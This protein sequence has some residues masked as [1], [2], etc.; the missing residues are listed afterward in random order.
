MKHNLGIKACVLIVFTLFTVA[1][2]AQTSI[3]NYKYVIVPE[4]FNFSKEDNQYSLNSTVKFL[5][6]QKGF[7][8]FIG[9][10]E[11]PSIV[12]ANRCNALTAEVVQNSG[13]FVTKL[14]LLLKDCQGNIIFKSKEGRSREKEFSSA[15]NQALRDAFSS[16]NDEP[17]KYDS[18]NDSQQ[19]HV[20]MASVNPSTVPTSAAIGEI[21]DTLYAQSTT[22]GYQLIDMTPKKVLV[23]FKTSMQD[24]FIAEAG[25]WHGVVFKKEGEWIFEYYKNDKLVSQKLSIRF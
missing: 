17:Y 18:T 25:A 7:T 22:N 6:D 10:K 15:Y 4:R 1:G 2:R 8:A 23:L 20:V 16:L 3:S 11:L 9:N 21:T 5:L 14:T 12:V 13:L 19:Q 24:Y